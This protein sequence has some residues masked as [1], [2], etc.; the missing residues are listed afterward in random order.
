[1]ILKRAFFIVSL[2]TII[3]SCKNSDSGYEWKTLDVSVSAYNAVSSQTDGKPNIAAWGDTLIPGEK[4]IAVSRDLIA[5]GLQHNALV[6]IEGLESTYV[7][8]DKMN[9]RYTKKIDIFMGKDVEKA[10]LWGIQKLAIQYR[11]KK[12]DSTKN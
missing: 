12:I 9:S 8:K 10:K 7:V 1:M 5:L 11:V 6:R 4:C 2:L 3:L